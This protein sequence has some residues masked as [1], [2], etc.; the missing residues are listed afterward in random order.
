VGVPWPVL[1]EVTLESRLL[2]GGRRADRGSGQA[3]CAAGGVSES[4]GQPEYDAALGGADLDGEPR[5]VR[6]PGLQRLGDGLE[7]Q[8]R[9]V[10][11]FPVGG[12]VRLHRGRTA[13]GGRSGGARSA[14]CAVDLGR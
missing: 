9:S 10:P 12:R 6:P 13:R 8:A 2:R 3:V 14:P 4:E 11:G 5:C 7:Q 1:K